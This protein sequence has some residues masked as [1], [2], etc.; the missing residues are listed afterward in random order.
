M[1]AVNYQ[2][3]QRIG[4]DITS[5]VR[6]CVLSTVENEFEISPYIT[7]IRNPR[8][9]LLYTR[10]CID[11]HCLATCKTKTGLSSDISCPLCKQGDETV[12]HLLL[13]CGH[14]AAN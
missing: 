2:F 9:R 8:V 1:V 6:F 12:E 14:F 10:L 11:L 13:T 5:S 7:K 3:L 4:G